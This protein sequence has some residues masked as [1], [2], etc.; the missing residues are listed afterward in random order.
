MS[1][2]AWK[3]RIQDILDAIAEIR[4]FTQG[5]DQKVA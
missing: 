4:V 1:P 3:E 2:R 5:C